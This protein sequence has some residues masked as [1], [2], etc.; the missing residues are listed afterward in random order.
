MLFTAAPPPGLAAAGKRA[1]IKRRSGK[2]RA[3]TKT[4]AARRATGRFVGEYSVLAERLSIT[5]R[6]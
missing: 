2:A 1:A 3:P 5:L 6:L 4:M